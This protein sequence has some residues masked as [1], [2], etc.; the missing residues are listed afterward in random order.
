MGTRLAVAEIIPGYLEK[1]IPNLGRGSRR[2][3]LDYNPVTRAYILRVPRGKEPSPQRLMREYGFDF[4]TP[5]STAQVATLFTREP[6]CAATFV[7]C[8]TPEAARQLA[9]IVSGVARSWALDSQAHI[10]VPDD[11]E[12]APYEK[13]CV[14]SN[15]WSERAE[16]APSPSWRSSMSVAERL[17]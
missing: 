10:R 1:G 5:A 15:Q 17:V 13:A 6:Y 11:Q 8:A 4:S 2:M 14:D 12:L 3:I 16:C 9:Q 7:D